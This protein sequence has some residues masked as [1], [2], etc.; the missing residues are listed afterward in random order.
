VPV[1]VM[2]GAVAPARA[3]TRRRRTRWHRPS[4]SPAPPFRPPRERA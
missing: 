2:N 1:A 3:G 4:C